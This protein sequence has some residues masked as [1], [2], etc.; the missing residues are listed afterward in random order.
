MPEASSRSLEPTS[1][2]V[3]GV[4]D[5]TATGDGDGEVGVAGAEEAEAVGEDGAVVAAVVGECALAFQ[6]GFCCL[7]G[8]IV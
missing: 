1:E 2:A 8:F 6:S 7:V 3:V 4:D 5:V